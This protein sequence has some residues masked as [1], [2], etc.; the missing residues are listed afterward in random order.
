M[1]QL[2]TTM[3]QDPRWS[4][5]SAAERARLVEVALVEM[6]QAQQQGDE[7]ANRALRS[8]LLEAGRKGV[9]S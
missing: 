6:E 8:L 3:G 9:E 5:I 1:A 2:E 4:Q 7:A